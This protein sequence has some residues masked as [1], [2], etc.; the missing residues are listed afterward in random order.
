M[1]RPAILLQT[2]ESALRDGRF[3][4]ALSAKAEIWDDELFVKASLEVKWMWLLKKCKRK[5]YDLRYALSK[6]VEKEFGAEFVDEA[7]NKYD[8]INS[9]IPIGGFVE[10]AAFID[11]IET[12]KTEMERR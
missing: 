1:P 11:M 2:K 9:G 3:S 10:T 12:V 4:V 8:K 6:W 7:L 5:H